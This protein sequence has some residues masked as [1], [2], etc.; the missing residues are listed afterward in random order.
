MCGIYIHA[1][2]KQW[3][4][5]QDSTHRHYQEPVFNPWGGGIAQREKAVPG[6]SLK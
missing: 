5:E 3:E 1:L 6:V 2:H 4:K